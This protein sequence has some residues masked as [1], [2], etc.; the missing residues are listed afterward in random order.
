MVW[1]WFLA[2]M[3]HVSPETVL[4]SCK[5][6]LETS[7]LPLLT[8]L[9]PGRCF[10]TEADSFFLVVFFCFFFI[11][12]TAS[13]KHKFQA[14][15]PS[16]QQKMLALLISVTEQWVTNCLVISIKATHTCHYICPGLNCSLCTSLG[17]P[18]IAVFLNLLS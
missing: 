9:G 15:F 2:S 11:L 16:T 6:I 14:A 13:K 7:S 10:N 4:F 17:C 1:V 12:C 5:S 3:F 18:G 8:C